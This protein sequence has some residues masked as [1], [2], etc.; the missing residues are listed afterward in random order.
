MTTMHL[1]KVADI[2]RETADTVS[3]AFDVPAHLAATY[4]FQQGQYLQLE[5]QLQGEAVR[6]SYSIFSAPTDG[7]LRVAIKHVPQG[8]FS[9][10]ANTQLAVGDA[11]LVMPPAGSSYR[12][13]TQAAVHHCLG[14]ASGS[15]I[16]AL[17]PI[18]KTTLENDERSRF[19]LVYGNRDRASM[20]FAERL[21]A[22][23]GVYAERLQLILLFSRE[24]NHNG[25]PS[26]RLD[27]ATCDALFREWVDV[28]LLDAAFICGPQAMVETVGGA[29][30]DYGLAA[31][32]L[33]FERFA[34]PQ[35]LR[36]A[37]PS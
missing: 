20:L 4:Q 21:D 36:E 24:A 8:R 30:K 3:I 7:E 23:K 5:A 15:G 31:E 1:L 25:L 26:G 37:L 12:P 29:L 19:T 28:S 6:R 33:H 11:L 13:Q 32:R 14:M 27:I 22:L 18:I 16:T 10:Y 9:S 17:L 2:R 35:P 34:E